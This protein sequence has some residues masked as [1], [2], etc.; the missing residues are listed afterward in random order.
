MLQS[1]PTVRITVAR[2]SSSRTRPRATS[3]S[4]GGLRRSWIVTPR[5]FARAANSSSSPRMGWSPLQI[6]RRG[7]IASRISERH[8]AGSCPP[9]GAIPMSSAFGCFASPSPSE[10]TT[11]MLPPKPSTS[12][13]VSPARVESMTAT[14][15][16]GV[17]RMQAF[18]VFDRRGL[19]APSA[20]MR[21]REFMCLGGPLDGGV[22][23]DGNDVDWWTARDDDAPARRGKTQ[24]ERPLARRAAEALA[25]VN[26]RNENA[27]DD[28]HDHGQRRQGHNEP[29]AAEEL[30]HDQDG[31]DRQHGRQVDL[32]GHRIGGHDVPLDEMHDDTDAEHEHRPHAAIRS[33]EDEERRQRR[34]Q[35]GAEEG[36]DRNETG[37]DP[38]G[39][40]E[41]HVEEVEEH[42]RQRREERHDEQLPDDVGAERV[43]QIAKQVANE[44]AMDRREER[45]EPLAVERWVE[46][47]IDRDDGDREE[48]DRAFHDA[49]HAR[50]K[51]REVARNLVIE[52]DED[53]VLAGLPVVA[54]GGNAID[55]PLDASFPSR[56][57]I[58]KH[59]DERLGLL[60]YRRDEDP[61][62]H[63]DAREAEKQRRREREALGEVQPSLQPARDGTEVQ[64]DQHSHEQQ[65]EN[66]RNPAEQ[67]QP[68]NGKNR[69]G[70]D[71][72]EAE[73][74]LRFAGQ[75]PFFSLSVSSISACTVSSSCPALLP[76]C[77]SCRCAAGDP[78][79]S[80]PIL[81]FSSMS[82]MSTP[83]DEPP[84]WSCLN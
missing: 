55:R 78:A 80:I 16:S 28:D 9:G 35:E 66:L 63:D 45:D 17:Y 37:E 18:A 76:P 31:H 40:R 13:A 73:P 36:D 56:D 2:S 59:L 49:E 51:G 62:D 6:S 21:K 82:R 38:K 30:A 50:R 72:G 64:R 27:P 58:R 42:R 26:P 39:Q 77:P 54:Q 81:C 70:E 44:V 68:E 67:P 8:D 24:D 3:R 65:D 43:P 57:V 79:G 34:G 60:D 41:R 53:L 19:K 23:S 71:G 75:L 48:T 69:R 10:A 15:C 25:L 12:C 7:S 84:R 4:L 33:I 14:T 32:L 11:G 1:V 20:R 47:E 5:L 22:L 29:D 46:R 52:R 83:D 61:E 74:P